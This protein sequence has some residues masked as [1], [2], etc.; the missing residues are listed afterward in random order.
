MCKGGRCLGT[1][2]ACTCDLEVRISTVFN[3]IVHFLLKGDV[4]GTIP[5]G[6]DYIPSY[7]ARHKEQLYIRSM[8]GNLNGFKDTGALLVRD[9]SVWS[10]SA[11][12][13]MLLN[14]RNKN[15]HGLWVRISTVFNILEHLVFIRGH[16]HHER[17]WLTYH[18]VLLDTRNKYIWF[19]DGYIN[20]FV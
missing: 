13:Q 8:G 7:V 4:R 16:D 2:P 5:Y 11:C 19:K 9:H 20:D 18:Q 15:I 12:H 3:I 10:W 14:T 17:S 6:H 1:P